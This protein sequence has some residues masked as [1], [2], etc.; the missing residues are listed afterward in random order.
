MAKT[1]CLL[2]EFWRPHYFISFYS[3]N[4]SVC[5]FR[6]VDLS[7]SALLLVDALEIQHRRDFHPATRWWV[8]VFDINST[9][10]Q[11]LTHAEKLEHLLNL[12]FR[13]RNLFPAE[14]AI[15][16]LVLLCGVG[17]K[18]KQGKETGCFYFPIRSI[19]I[20][21]YVWVCKF[22]CM[23]VLLIFTLLSYYCCTVNLQQS[24]GL[25]RK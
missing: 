25:C 1:C 19:Y 12:L 14:F 2:L 10:L 7:A 21:M 13:F 18:D 11:P 6:T 23:C 15:Y 16:M 9:T 17:G 24:A 4:L 5:C 3:E 20:C 8:W 22:E